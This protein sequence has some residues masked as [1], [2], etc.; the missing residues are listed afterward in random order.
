[1]SISTESLLKNLPYPLFAKEGKHILPLAKGG[2]ERF[3]NQCLHTYDRILKSSLI[4]GGGIAEC[5]FP[6]N[7]RRLLF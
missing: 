7:L 5:P 3:Y 1:M 4:T 2:E 6:L